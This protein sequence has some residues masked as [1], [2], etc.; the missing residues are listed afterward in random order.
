MIHLTSTSCI[1][2]AVKPQ[3]FRKQIDGLV[4]VVQQ[5]FEMD[6]RSGAMYVFI[7]RSKTMVRIL[8]YKGNGY[9]CATKRLTKG[10]FRGWPKSK[11]PMCDMAAKHL[12]QLIKGVPLTEVANT[13]ALH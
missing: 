11:T 13:K 3:D 4:A 5:H 12:C 9:W 8:C 1:H 7:N 10:K 6:P 2:L